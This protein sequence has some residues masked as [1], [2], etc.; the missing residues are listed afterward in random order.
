MSWLAKE[1]EHGIPMAGTPM[2]NTHTAQDNADVSMQGSITT[3]GHSTESMATSGSDTPPGIGM[4][5]PALRPL[6]SNRMLSSRKGT[7]PYNA[8]SHSAQLIGGLAKEQNK[9][10]P[11]LDLSTCSTKAT[12]DMIMKKPSVS[13]SQS[14]SS[15]KMPP[16]PSSKSITNLPNKST[17]TKTT[18]PTIQRAQSS[19]DVVRDSKHSKS[20]LKTNLSVN[21]KQ[22]DSISNSEVRPDSYIHRESEVYM[23]DILYHIMLDL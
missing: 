7:A 10:D 1:L 8:I 18:L 16:I 5:P 12:R 15:V 11:F 20:K 6:T 14:Q 2:G 3:K 17:T 4:G 22:N 13:Q 9:Q 21:I 19:S 23:Y